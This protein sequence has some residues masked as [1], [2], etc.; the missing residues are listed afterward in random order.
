[1]TTLAIIKGFQQKHRQIFYY[2]D[3]TEALPGKSPIY[4]S[5]LIESLLK[6]ELI[7]RLTKGIFH[8]IPGSAHPKDFK[9]GWK[10]IAKYLAKKKPYYLGYQSAM[11][12]HGLTNNEVTPMLIVNKKHFRPSTVN[13]SGKDY[14]YITLV[15]TRFF[16]IEEIYVDKYESI[17]VSNLEK[18][19]VDITS[20]PQLSGGIA[21]V[22]QALKN[23]SKRLD[24]NRLFYY[25]IRNGNQAAIKRYLYLYSLLKL[26]WTTDHDI[27]LENTAKGY[28]LL[29]P[30]EKAQGK[31]NS[32]F[33]LRINTNSTLIE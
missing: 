9:P 7:I 30:S 19:I 23:T 13:I 18:T 1:M 29:D 22:A 6:K 27:M 12:I 33:G 24:N 14:Q 17:N 26:E 16:G 10:L 11:H 8:I 20:K 25:F 15:S 21:E 5:K 4:Y 28:S 2:S 32:K 3:L 31:L